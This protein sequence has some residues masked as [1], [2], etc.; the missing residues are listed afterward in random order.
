MVFAF[1]GK[2]VT[3]V[4]TRERVKGV[5]SPGKS[6]G[7]DC[8][9]DCKEKTTGS[10]LGG[11]NGRRRINVK[12]EMKRFMASETKRIVGKDDDDERGERG[13]ERDVAD[14]GGVALVV[15]RGLLHESVQRRREREGETG[16]GGGE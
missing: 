12:R 6:G 8:D 3:R 13:R 14:D 15:V 1:D 5:F 9:D 7:E 11:R 16:R 4:E 10:A 2:R